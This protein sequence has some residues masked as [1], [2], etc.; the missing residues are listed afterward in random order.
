MI[1]ADTSV[2][3]DH[4]RKNDAELV[5]QLHRNNISIHPFV[6][7]ELALGHLPDRLR[8]IATLDLLPAV[9]VAQ[10]SEVR[11]MIDAHALIRRGLGFVDAHLLAS[12]FLTPHTGLWTR[13]KQL[14]DAAK[15]MG[16]SASLP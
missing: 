11:H 1:L 16:L 15:M 6:V 7:T 13:D 9:K 5:R 3:V 8:T 4:F 2:W 10:T 12:A 14:R